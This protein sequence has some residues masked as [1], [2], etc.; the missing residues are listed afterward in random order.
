MNKLNKSKSHA[1]RFK[2]CFRLVLV[3][4]FCSQ[5]WI[6]LSQS[7]YLITIH[8]SSSIHPLFTLSV[9]LIL[10]L[11][12]KQKG[13]YKNTK[14]TLSKP[15]W[16]PHWMSWILKLEIHRCFREVPNLPFLLKRFQNCM[17]FFHFEVFSK[18][19]LYTLLQ[20][21]IWSFMSRL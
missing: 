1:L 11:L 4:W 3:Q 13:S 15:A 12:W 19:G 20:D 2:I 8:Q 21:Y 16:H 5:N 9:L 18:K 7:Q 10:I 6:E 14:A 17:L